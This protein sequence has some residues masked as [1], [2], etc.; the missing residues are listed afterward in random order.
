ML[1][2]ILSENHNKL[3]AYVLVHEEMKDGKSVLVL[4][5]ERQGKMIYFIAKV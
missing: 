5:K 4:E 2:G 3:V 1:R